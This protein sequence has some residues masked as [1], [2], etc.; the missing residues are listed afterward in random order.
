[1]QLQ[2]IYAVKY[3]V[4]IARDVYAMRLLG[5]T[6]CFTA[7]GQF[8][9]V[10]IEGFYLRRPF[11]VCRWDSKGLEI[12]Y[13]TLG[14]GTAHLAL[15][16]PGTQLDVL[17]GLG[18]GFDAAAAGGKRILLVG[19]GVGVPPLY[20]LAAVLRAR[21]QRP[22]V[23]LGFQSAADAFYIDEFIK[24]GCETIVATEDG[25]LG[26]KGFVTQIMKSQAFDYYYSC[27]PNAMLE[28][29]YRLGEEMG[30]E[31]QLSFEE[32]MGCGTGACMGCSHKTK[33]GYKRV[34]ADGPV[35][36]SR[37]VVFE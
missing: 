10:Q 7:P 33:D 15:F 34:C 26:E 28:A 22:V 27:G 3:N 14:T 4:A 24:L 31:G 2:A 16:G 19:G 35:F 37:E 21:G 5:P 30:A 9:N 8:I 6:H 25:S 29:V 1:M 23:A 20:A 13:K 18:N 32:R 11:S 36:T 17:A 12:I